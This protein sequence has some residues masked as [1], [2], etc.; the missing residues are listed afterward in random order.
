DGIDADDFGAA[1]LARRG[2]DRRL[3][4][5]RDDSVDVGIGATWK[6]AAGKLDLDVR[7]D[8]AGASDGYALALDYSRPLALGRATLVPSVGVVRLSAGMADYY[9]GTLDK[10]IA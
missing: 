4:E 5:D 8:V 2:V 7:A 10:E 6:G 3:L 1:A 9:Y